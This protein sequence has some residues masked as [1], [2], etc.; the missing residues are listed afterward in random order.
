MDLRELLLF[1]VILFWVSSLHGWVLFGNGI[2]GIGVFGMVLLCMDLFGYTSKQ[3]QRREEI[4]NRREQFDILTGIKLEELKEVTKQEQP[5]ETKGLGAKPKQLKESKA[6]K[7]KKAKGVGAKPK[8]LKESEAAKPKE[9]KE[10]EAAKPKKAKGVGAKPKQLKESEAAK[11][12]QLKESEA[13]KPKQLKESEAAKPKEAKE[14][15]A[16][17]PKE[18]KEIEAAK[19]KEAKE[20]EAAKPKEAKEIESAKPIEAEAAK[21]KEAKETEAAK[22]KKAKETEAAKPKEAKET[23]A[24]KPKEAKE[25]EAAKPKEAKEIES[26]KPIEAEAA[27]PKEAKETEAA[28]LKKAKE[29]EAAKPKEAKETEAVKPQEAKETEV[30][31]PKEAKETEAAKPKETKEIE[32]A[33]P[34]EAKETEAAKPK[35]AK[36]TKAA[37]PKKAKEIEAVKPKKAKETKAAKPKKAKE[38]EA[39]KPKESK[40]VGAKPK[41]AIKTDSTKQK[42][43]EYVSTKTDPTIRNQTSSLIHHPQSYSTIST[44]ASFAP[45]WPSR[46]SCEDVTVLDDF[47]ISQILNDEKTWQ[48]VHRKSRQQTVSV[49]NSN[50]QF[51]PAPL[52]NYEYRLACDVCFVKQ[53]EGKGGCE[54]KPDL[55]HVCQQKYLLV[56]NRNQ[57]STRTWLKIRPRPTNI[58]ESGINKPMLTWLNEFKTFKGMYILCQQIQDGRPCLKGDNNCRFAHSV[59]EITF[60]DKDRVGTFNISEFISRN[61]RV[62]VNQYNNNFNKSP[63]ST[64]SSRPALL[65]TPVTSTW[66]SVT[67]TNYKIDQSADGFP[68]SDYVWKLVCEICFKPGLKLGE[69]N[70]QNVK[71]KCGEYLLAVRKRT[72]NRWQHVRERN[73]FFQFRGKFSYCNHYCNGFPCQIPEGIPACRFVH[74]EPE[75]DLWTLER[76]TAGTFSIREF[77]STHRTSTSSSSSSSADVNQIEI[78]FENYGGELGFI[79]LYCYYMH[80]LVHKSNSSDFCNTEMHVWSESRILSHRSV[81]GAIT[82]IFLQ[83]SGW[84]HATPSFEMCNKMHLCEKR[85][86]GNCVDAHSLIERDLWKLARDLNLTHDEIMTRWRQLPLREKIPEGMTTPGRMTTPGEMTTPGRVTTPGG[87]TTLGRVTTPGGMTT[88]GRVTTPGGMTTPGRVTAPGV[89]SVSTPQN[90]W[91]KKCPYH[92]VFVCEICL[93]NGIFNQKLPNSNKCLGD[94][95]NFDINKKVISLPS[96]VIINPK[97]NISNTR[98]LLCNLMNKKM[99]CQRAGVCYFAHNEDERLIWS[100]MAVNKIQTL[101][102]LVE[103]SV[104][105]FKPHEKQS[106]AIPRQTSSSGVESRSNVFYCQ[107]CTVRCNSSTQWEIHCSSDTHMFNINSDK[108]R[109]WNYRQPP[110]GVWQ[111]RYRLCIPHYAREQCRYS[112]VGDMYNSCR[113]AHTQDELDE[114]KER[115]RWRQLKKQ[116]AMKSGLYSYM[117]TLTEEYEHAESDILVITENLPDINV[118]VDSELRVFKQKKSNKHTW[119]FQIKCLKDV[120]LEKVA[121]L[122]N[123]DRLHFSLSGPDLDQNSQLASGEKFQDETNKVEVKVK[124]QGGM[125]GSFSQWLIFDFGSRPV[126]VRKLQVEVGSSDVNEK[127]KKV[128][129]KLKFERWTSE[130]CEIIRCGQ[131]FQS[132]VN[133]T[134]LRRYKP[135]T[136]VEAVINQGVFTET[137]NQ[138]NYVHKLHQILQLEEFTRHALISSFNVKVEVKLSSEIEEETHLYSYHNE[139]FACIPLEEDLVPDTD[140]GHLI[141]TTVKHVLVA[142]DVDGIPDKVYEAMLVEKENFGYNG[143]GREY[144]YICLSQQCVEQCGLVAGDKVHLEVQF[145]MNRHHLCLMHYALDHLADTDVVYPDIRKIT[146]CWTDVKQFEI[147]SIVLNKDQIDAVDQMINL[148]TGYTAP[149]IIYGPFGT[150]KTETIAQGVMLLLKQRRDVRILISTHSN[151]AADLYILKHLNK[152]IQ[153]QKKTIKIGRLIQPARRVETVHDD[154]SYYCFLSCDRRNFILPTKQQLLECQVVIATMSMAPYLIS[155]EMRGC[156]THILLDEAAQAMECETIMPLVLATDKTCTV[157]AGDYMQMSP[158]IYSDEAR[159]QDFDQSLLERLYK[160]YDFNA[161]QLDRKNASRLKI[162][163]TFNYRTRMEILRFISAVFYGGPHQLIACSNDNT[164]I[165]HAAMVFYTTRGREIQQTDSTSFY[166]TAEIDEVVTRVEELYERWPVTAW[167]EK[168]AET[169]AVVT[170]YHDQVQR[171]RRALRRSK[172]KQLKLVTVETVQNVQGKEFR[173]VFISTVRTRHLIES[174]STDTTDAGNYGFLSDQKLLNTALTRAESLVAVVGDP[175][176]L[177]AI[178]DCMTVWRTFLKHCSNLNSIVPKDVTF[179]GVKTDVLNLL[180]SQHFM[181]NR[182]SDE[183][184]T[185]AA[186]TA[187]AAAAVTAAT[188]AAVIK[189]FTN[190][191]VSVEISASNDIIDV[192]YQ[193]EEIVLNADEIIAELARDVIKRNEMESVDSGISQESIHIRE[194]CDHAIIKYWSKGNYFAKKL[195]SDGFESD[196]SSDEDV[197]VAPSVL[198]LQRLLRLNPNKYIKSV[199]TI[200]HRSTGCIYAEPVTDGDASARIII[201]SRLRCGEGFN[202]DVAVVELINDDTATDPFDYRHGNEPINRH[203]YVVGILKRS[204]DPTN[205]R[206][207][208]SVEPGNSGLMVPINSGIPKIY[209]LETKHRATHSKR[210]FVTVYRVT[211]DRRFE[212]DHYESISATCEQDHKLFIVQYLKWDKLLH[213]PLGVVTRVFLQPGATIDRGIQIL[214]VEHDIKQKF[215]Q[216]VESKIQQQYPVGF[217]LSVTARDDLRDLLVFTITAATRE[218]IDNGFSVE[219]LADGG[220]RIG[221]HVSDVSEFISADTV[222]DRE[223]RKRSVSKYPIGQDPVLL[224]PERLAIDL[225]SLKPSFDR[226][227]ISVVMTIDE[228]GEIVNCE[229]K[230]SI[231]ISRFKFSFA[232]AQLIL[233]NGC[234]SG[235][236][237]EVRDAMMTLHR[238]T[239][240]WRNDRLGNARLYDTLSEL[241]DA[242]H[243]AK[244]L[245]EELQIKVN[246]QIAKYLLNKL[247]QLTPLVTQAAPDSQKL[248]TW[249]QQHWLDALNTVAMTHAFLPPGWICDCTDS[250]DCI[251][252]EIGDE[253]AIYGE[254]INLRAEVWTS[255]ETADELETIVKLVVS[256]EVHPH[257]AIA[258][259]KL[260]NIQKPIEY[261]CSGD[262]NYHRY[263]L[264]N[265]SPFTCFTSPLHRFV[266]IVV[267]RLL[268]SVITRQPIEYTRSDIRMICDE[269]T[270]AERKAKTFIDATLS[271]HVASALKS[272]PIVYLPVINAVSSETISLM[273]PTLP[274]NIDYPE[275]V[276]TIHL[277]LCDSP[278]HDS[279]R[280]G[281]N[282]RWEKRIY[283]LNPDPGLLDHLA[284]RHDDVLSLNPNRFAVQ[285]PAESWQ[286]LLHSVIGGNTDAIC[287]EMGLLRSEV[288]DLPGI[289]RYVPDVIVGMVTDNNTRTKRRYYSQFEMT[290]Q[291]GHVTHVQISTHVVNAMLKPTVQ[292]IYITDRLSLCIEHMCEPLRCFLHS[293]PVPSQTVKIS[294]NIREYIDA[295]LPL[296]EMEGIYRCVRAG[297]PSITIHNV[298]IA[299]AAAGAVAV[300][301]GTVG[302][303]TVGP[304]AEN[305]G[306]H[307]GIFA[308][309]QGFCAERNI[310]F[311]PSINYFCIKYPGL[312]VDS[313]NLDPACFIDPKSEGLT[314]YVTHAISTEILQTDAQFIVALDFIETDSGR[315]PPQLLIPHSNIPCT[316][317]MFTVHQSDSMIQQFIRELSDASDFVKNIVLG[318]KQS[319]NVEKLSCAQINV[320]GLSI[321]NQSQAKAYR[322][323]LQHPFT[324]IQGPAGSGKTETAVRIITGFVLHNRTSALQRGDKLKVVCCCPTESSADCVA[325]VLKLVNVC[326]PPLDITRV[327]SQSH[328]EFLFCLPDSTLP[329]SAQ[330]SNHLKVKDRHKEIALHH[331]IRREH[332]GLDNHQGSERLSLMEDMKKEIINCEIL[333]CTCRTFMRNMIQSALNKCQVT[334]LVIDDNNMISEPE[335]IA[336]I[337]ASKCQQIILLGDSLQLQ[338]FVIS[339]EARSLGLNKSL[340]SRYENKAIRL[341]SQY[342]MHEGLAKLPSKLWYENSLKCG[343]ES[344]Q[345]KGSPINIWPAGDENPIVFAHVVGNEEFILLPSTADDGMKKSYLNQLEVLYAVSIGIELISKRSISAESVAILTP[346]EAQ[347][348]ELTEVWKQETNAEI[349]IQTINESQ[350]HEWNYV[351]LSTVRSCPRSMIEKHPTPTWRNLRLGCL[352]D[353]NLVNVALTRAK[354]GLI[355]IGNQFLLNCCEPWNQL[356]TSYREMTA[357]L[358]AEDFI[359]QIQNSR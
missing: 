186:V 16:A 214:S 200:D 326:S 211:D 224:L 49:T 106:T 304:G 231:V 213:S 141:L 349:Q 289:D 88:P 210:G 15:E 149:L 93:K 297:A 43:S 315:I 204:I 4:G 171:I 53:K 198:C 110:W 67:N 191:E 249:K 238:L 324:V 133:Q 109:Q 253:S 182:D 279:V 64:A 27:K 21:P 321:P 30:V 169:I 17:K 325:D 55:K 344:K 18:A 275:S 218:D 2:Y 161:R 194:F 173:A 121:L 84:R 330:Y 280:S 263:H 167:G 75:R 201:T 164:T 248:I 82:L 66:P 281:V 77:I 207:V 346:Y 342:R 26:A 300:E 130:N 222:V 266:D 39:A 244:R 116:M 260:I 308:I 278:V 113:F 306:K 334:Q 124:F 34:K 156:F 63:R 119:C 193:E 6:A 333:L 103:L 358:K 348:V 37:K 270:V 251:L 236:D 101:K 47:E 309:D 295:W 226:L 79:C 273:F 65:P 352:H 292:L 323:A 177:C 256:P 185:A 144:I 301:P 276:S 125:F 120:K 205:R 10:I 188:T 199:L 5:K 203:G 272:R 267:Q 181:S 331:K 70:L 104:E 252:A 172:H 316:I 25:T 269:L 239:Q 46:L 268:K 7:P 162:L 355:I 208:C 221:V 114:W 343:M 115:Y 165:E 291:P 338:P 223:A 319:R 299:H 62:N 19:P 152:F 354:N 89:R 24:V 332:Q 353:P 246:Y 160:H 178:G 285:I 12:K 329:P 122:Q 32:A 225:C 107:Y 189:P 179:I 206:F 356:L 302:P 322:A 320:P 96:K 23:E 85:I 190:Q 350:G 271:L 257:L 98:F 240:Q 31:K 126:L 90:A 215:T 145:Q 159:Q 305:R 58:H 258:L 69:W 102:R 283:D 135:A 250:C 220:F 327:Y 166:N 303:G 233:K 229:F 265:L 216:E 123:K 14:T 91:L 87:M 74:N 359:S 312:E 345:R 243:H 341:E 136:A 1:G 196:E 294:S 118:T 183:T 328:E 277:N 153:Q 48:N 176:A 143:K 83:P 261:C 54:F 86:L 73:N 146:P 108:E 100:W 142:V 209:N 68:L 57:Q 247:P 11:P 60:W 29:T 311:S 78:L 259:Q 195:N 286:S 202:G 95:A 154:V 51:L 94:H 33:K 318:K 151:S 127:V 50:R 174:L 72:D 40:G 212:F 336:V 227:A 80:Q 163:L 134:E 180:N 61:R 111:G 310:S 335:S 139:L 298:S 155:Q 234:H 76:D 138:H 307:I 282:L 28:K 254:M 38:T 351:I 175:V 262:S 340:F 288:S 56:R 36:E 235:N 22:L 117:D 317:E 339:D 219:S 170:P 284:R 187:T 255:I 241:D 314:T 347:C 148:R 99:N 105:S 137:L 13:A 293:T 157:V 264:L 35:E 20:T 228:A 112:N 296:L 168:R 41:Q 81:T 274:S 71:H 237:A 313:G 140:A 245:V 131:W 52:A 287:S 290:L 45:V 92:V 184:A 3:R 42:N 132:V 9:A 192:N 232:E 230:R 147:D 158:K 8:Q 217:F 242:T 128:R 44:M 337:S 97:P 129:D 357:V 197:T 150:G 59:E